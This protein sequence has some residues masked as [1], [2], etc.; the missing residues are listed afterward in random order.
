MSAYSETVQR[1]ARAYAES[2]QR[3]DT[4]DK[5]SPVKRGRPPK[6]RRLLPRSE[7]R[8]LEQESRARHLARNRRSASVSRL[9][10]RAAAAE[11]Q[12]RLAYLTEDHAKLNGI[13]DEL[14][15]ETDVLR[16][17]NIALRR[18]AVPSAFRR[19]EVVG[20]TRVSS[21]YTSLPRVCVESCVGFYPGETPHMFAPAV[22]PTDIESPPIA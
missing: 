12:L 5:L 20:D 16:A 11:V 22:S 19:L 10:I 7:R 4:P 13:Y 18:A 17:E 14:R 9:R 1:M 6:S 21:T 15:R 3:K 2:M 8:V